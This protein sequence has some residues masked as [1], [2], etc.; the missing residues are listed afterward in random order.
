EIDTDRDGLKDW[1]ESIW[2]TDIHNPNTYGMSDTDYVKLQIEQ[3]EKTESLGGP[4]ETTEELSQRLFTEY[5]LLRQSGPVS[6][7][8]IALLTQ[9]LM[10]EMDVSESSNPYTAN[11]LVVFS[12]SD[13]QGIENYA[14]KLSEI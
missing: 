2:K 11:T 7:S 4:I 8:D 3:G 14:A 13:K 6:S 9:R 10:E 1:E 12:D 5:T